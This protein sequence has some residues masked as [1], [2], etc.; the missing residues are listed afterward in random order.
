MPI[1][2]TVCNMWHAGRVCVGACQ[3][4]LNYSTAR[5]HRIRITQI[6]A[7]TSKR[8]FP[9]TKSPVRCC[10]NFML[11]LTPTRHST[12]QGKAGQSKASVV[13]CILA[14]QSVELASFAPR[15]GDNRPN[16]RG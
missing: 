11:L 2:C 16:R 15:C 5:S 4:T 13:D 9:P 6:K 14:S 12:R 10:C 7:K 1:P 8:F 3:R